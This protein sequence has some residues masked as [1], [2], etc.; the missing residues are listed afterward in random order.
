ME[1]GHSGFAYPHVG[2]GSRVQGQQ[3]WDQQP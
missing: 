2:W 3:H 1:Q